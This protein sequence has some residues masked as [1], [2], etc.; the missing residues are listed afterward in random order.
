MSLLDFSLLY[1]E[2]QRQAEEMTQWVKFLASQ[3]WRL[4][5]GP[6]VQLTGA[7]AVTPG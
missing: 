4:E 7:L 1:Q 5:I 3:A 2:G 6:Q